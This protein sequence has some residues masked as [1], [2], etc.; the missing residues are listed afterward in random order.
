MRSPLRTPNP[1]LSSAPQ[2]SLLLATPMPAATISNMKGYTRHLRVSGRSE[3]REPTRSMPPSLE[4]P[5]LAWERII[6]WTNVGRRRAT[7]GV[8]L[9]AVTSREI[10]LPDAEAR[11]TGTWHTLT[12]VM[13]IAFCSKG[14]GCTPMTIAGA[15]AS[16][17]H[18]HRRRGV[19]RAPSDDI[20]PDC[21]HLCIR[22][23]G[24]ELTI[25]ATFAISIVLPGGFPPR[26]ERSR[27][28][29]YDRF[30]GPRA[31]KKISLAGIRLEA[32]ERDSTGGQKFDS[33]RIPTRGMRKRATRRG[34]RPPQFTRGLI[35]QASKS[36]LREDAPTRRGWALARGREI[37]L[38]SHRSSA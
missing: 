21:H 12:G 22:S 14:L 3:S 27:F 28:Q 23:S 9:L 33:A 34:E 2:T 38:V 31:I 25:R 26:Q 6:N 11:S 1:P 16:R 24:H 35:I 5:S 30:R 18:V 10:G 36:L 7:L 29:E 17:T 8:S 19:P 13:R 15:I 37:I 32:G 4:H 20:I